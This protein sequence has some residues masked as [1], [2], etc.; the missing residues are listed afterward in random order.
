MA[1][2]ARQGASS[3]CPWCE[4]PLPLIATECPDC[5]FPLTMA[6]TEGGL[7]ATGQS[8]T[9]STATPGG[10]RMPQFFHQAPSPSGDGSHKFRMQR[11][12]IMAWLL[13]ALSILVLLAGIGAVIS[14]SQPGARSDREASA[15]LFTALRRATD[16][17]GYRA[18]VLI[19]SLPGN[20]PSDQPA[21]I[22]TEQAQGFWYASALSTSNRCYLLAARLS[23]GAPLGRGTLAKN[24]PC[25]AAEVRLR[26]EDKLL[27]AAAP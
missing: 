6:A 3:R 27:K 24:E 18:G 17:P 1:K 26:L 19:T 2:R 4:A 20:E 15:N 8:G 23:D 22:S 11:I 14:S 16:D 10:A 5:R 12:R 21:R 25:T 13:G 7:R 9:S